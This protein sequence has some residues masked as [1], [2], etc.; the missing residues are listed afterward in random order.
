MR[1]DVSLKEILPLFE[2][3]KIEKIR[4]AEHLLT[5]ARNGSGGTSDANKILKECVDSLS[6]LVCF[7]KEEGESFRFSCSQ[8]NT[9]QI[10]KQED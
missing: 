8:Q 5:E 3:S 9:S 10:P 4:L 2:L 1:K 7:R 6:E